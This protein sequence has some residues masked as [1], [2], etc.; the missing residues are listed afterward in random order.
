MKAGASPDQMGGSAGRA[1]R[2]PRRLSEVAGLI[3]GLVLFSWLHNLAGTDV[4]SAMANADALQSAERSLNLDVEVAANHWLSGHLGLIPAVVTYYRLYYLPLV[5]V[6]LW[7]F[8]RHVEVYC[9]VLRNLVVMTALALVVF[10]LVPMAPPRFALPGIVDVVATH[11]PVA[12]RVS[13]DLANG[14]NHFSAMPSLHVGWS[15]LCAYAVWLA[16]R[17]RHPR[18]T[19]LAWLFPL[20]MV[21]VVIISGNHYVLDVAGSVLL[22]TISITAA[23]AWDR[24]RRGWR[25]GSQPGT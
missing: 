14:Q 13:R 10:W 24:W 25:A 16:A 21:A 4:A 9:T 20:V 5:A 18:L 8:F 7:T 3:V 11:D 6:L 17:S 23:K 1:E 12:G 2:K 22:L 19:L 15:A